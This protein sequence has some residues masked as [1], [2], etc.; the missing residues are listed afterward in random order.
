MS[1]EIELRHQSGSLASHS[2]R[3]KLAEG[4]SL[5]LGRNATCD[6]KFHDLA[7]DLVSGLHARLLYQQGRL[8]LEDQQSS[9]GTFLNGAKCPPLER[10]A[11]PEGSR[12]RLAAGGPELRVLL[13]SGEVAA[14]PAIGRETLRAELRGALSDDDQARRRRARHRAL[15]AG[16]TGLLL[17]LGALGLIGFWA[18][19]RTAQ[20]ASVQSLG[21]GAAPAWTEVEGR[22]R[23]AV[24]RVESRYSLVTPGSGSIQNGT[25]WGS[26]VLIAPTLVLTSAHLA[27]PWREAIG[28][29]L[30]DLT[31]SGKLKAAIDTLSVQLPGQEPVPATVYALASNADLA[32]LQIPL[33]L[34]T[35]L[36]VAAAGEPLEVA[37]DVGL[38]LYP[39]TV[40][41]P[42]LSA[43]GM[44]PTGTRAGP[45][46][47]PLFIKAFV[48]RLDRDA[49]GQPVGMTLDR[50]FAVAGGGGPVVNRRGELVGLTRSRL[51]A[52]RTISLAGRSVA[53][54]DYGAGTVEAV[55]LGAIRSFLARAGVSSPAP[56]PAEP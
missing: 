41:E 24:A 10:L 5:T 15:L 23:A 43:A 26:G 1:V 17:L 2:Q 33:R 56:V 19:E 36:A 46:A 35:P 32:L 4:Q 7:D 47:D 16:S 44:R 53:T 9:N 20:R 12:I 50:S 55:A 27:R 39:S 25:A 3:L 48:A 28:H 14:K 18:S 31:G 42:L 13:M 30:E 21:R 45:L 8:W 51:A 29:P 6:V 22:A 37:Q 11:V 40:A 54:K 52:A 49:G 38:L 34:T